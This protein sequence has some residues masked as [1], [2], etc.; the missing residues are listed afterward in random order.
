[1]LRSIAFL[2][3]DGTINVDDGY[4]CRPE[5]WEFLP[6]AVPSIAKLRENGFLVAVVSNQSGIGRGLLTAEDV[7]RLH[8]FVQTELSNSGAHI[9]A[10]AFCPHTPADNCD[11]RKPKTGLARQVEEMLGD[12]IDYPA[13]WTI[14][15]KVTDL[16]FGAALGTRTALIRSRYWSEGSLEVTPTIIADSLHDAVN[17]ILSNQA[18][19]VDC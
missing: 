5:Q 1:M 6:D 13:S 9:D 7:E 12:K 19:G 11:C 18:R 8:M 16:Q 10:I 15:D 2:D 17:H 3:R 4:V 14:G